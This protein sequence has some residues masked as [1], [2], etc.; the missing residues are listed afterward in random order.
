VTPIS[1]TVTHPDGRRVGYALWGDPQSRLP[2]VVHCHGTPGSRIPM[3]PVE[4]PEEHVHV[5]LD[6]PG[7]GL[8]DP[9]PGRQAAD[10]AGDVAAVL[11]ELGIDAFSALGWSGGVGPALGLGA[12]LPA[13][14]RRIVVGAG[15][16]PVDSPVFPTAM[17][18]EI[19][20]DLEKDRADCEQMARLF[21]ES[22]DSYWAEMESWLPPDELE[23][24]RSQ[25]P[26][27]S[28]MLT[29]AFENGGE[30]WFEDD[31]QLVTPW[32]FDLGDVRCEVQLWHGLDDGMVPPDNGRWL[33]EQL[34]RCEAHFVEGEG[35]G[36]LQRLLPD[37]CR[38][39]AG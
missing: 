4:M 20:G 35:H 3:Y 16:A 1:A 12:G 11:D 17:R 21:R 34:P 15:R 27:F 39:L 9:L 14:V 5:M 13:R 26:Q 28:A 37:M 36:S 7:W 29:A 23:K 32:G 8:S 24:F 18:D 33:A 22:P 38:W 10:H 19:L 25:R 2:V 31:V 6:R 30:G